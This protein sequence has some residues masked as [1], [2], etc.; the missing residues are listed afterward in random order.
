M[1]SG[2]DDSILARLVELDR[3]ADAAVEEAKAVL[4]DTLSHIEEDTER[5]RRTRAEESAQR[6][7]AV[8]ER[9]EKASQEQLESISRR[10]RSLT[11]EMEKTYRERHSQWED[12]IFRRCVGE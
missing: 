3:K 2:S 8:R 11:E 10:Y 12:E 9:E 6:I 1:M 5:F 4:D 7:S